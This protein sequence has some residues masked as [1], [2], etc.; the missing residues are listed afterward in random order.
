M[1]RMY[2]QRSEQTKGR[3]GGGKVLG[4]SAL[5]VPLLP[6]PLGEYSFVKEFE[7]PGL[8]EPLL[9]GHRIYG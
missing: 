5:S 3:V 9:V 4:L 6:R 7:V 1:L 8:P 2:S